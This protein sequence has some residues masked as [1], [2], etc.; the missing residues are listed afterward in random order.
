MDA[1][2]IWKDPDYRDSLDPDQLAAVPDNPAGLARLATGDAQLAGGTIQTWIV[3]TIGT[4]C[5]WD[6]CLPISWN[7]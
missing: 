4:P 5:T 1:V 7:C 3:C 2:R 6:V